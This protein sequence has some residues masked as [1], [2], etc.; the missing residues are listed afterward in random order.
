MIKRNIYE[1]LFDL[2]MSPTCSTRK[3]HIA[4]TSN[5][6]T[7]SIT[8]IF[9]IFFTM[10]YEKLTE[11]HSRLCMEIL[12]ILVQRTLASSAQNMFI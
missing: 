11:R 6:L 1:N 2:P 9:N 5:I 7:R 12:T 8:G 4:Y 10:M 3:Y